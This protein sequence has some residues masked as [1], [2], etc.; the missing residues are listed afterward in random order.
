MHNVLHDSKSTNGK[1]TKKA[2]M[3]SLKSKTLTQKQ[4]KRRTAYQL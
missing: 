3:K 2:L 1:T 4:F